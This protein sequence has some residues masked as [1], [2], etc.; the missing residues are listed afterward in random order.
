[1]T[2]WYFGDDYNY[3][4]IENRAQLFLFLLRATYLKAH[5]A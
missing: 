5:G 1:M 2:L 3:I 4:V